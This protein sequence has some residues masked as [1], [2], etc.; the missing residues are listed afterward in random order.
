MR[1]GIFRQHGR[2][3]DVAHLHDDGTGAFTIQQFED[4]APIVDHVK[5]LSDL[6][7][8]RADG[9][10]HEAEIPDHVL[11]RSFLEGWFHDTEAWRRWCND[12]ENAAFRI[13]H[14]GRINR[15]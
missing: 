8:G 4:C 13:Q 3:I 11:R 1:R 9:L 10:R 5:A 12:P 15:L 14:N 2:T 6:P 7:A